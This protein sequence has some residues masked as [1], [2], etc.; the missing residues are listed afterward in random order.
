MTSILYLC[1]DPGIPI[2]GGKGASVHVRA[3][4]HA[5]AELGHHVTVVSPRLEPGGE[6]L[7]AQVSALEIPGVDPKRAADRHELDALKR[8]QT[9]ALTTLVAP[10]SID[11]I[12]ERYSLHGVAGARLAAALGCPLLLE[13]NAPLRD[14]ARRFRSL[15]Y[16]D[17]AL[18]DEREVL[19]AARRVFVVSEPLAEWLRGEGVDAGRI[20]VAPNAFPPPR[21]GP[22]PPLGPDEPA[23]VG[24]AGGLKPWHGI[25]TLVRGFEMALREGARMRLEVAGTG[26][27]TDVLE[28]LS[29][30]AE[31][32]LWHGHLEHGAM[33]GLLGEW[34]IGAAPFTA[35]PGFYFSPLKLGEYMA[36]GL[37]PLVS[38]LP[39]LRAMLEQGRCGML[40][41]PDDPGALCA[42]LLELDRDRELMHRLGS[43]A[44]ERARRGPTWPDIVRQVLAAA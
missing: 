5:M 12:W 30:P 36:A 23:I 2:H 3:L 27:R 7:P 13:V 24:F 22:K 6:A 42:A 41:A 17:G 19:A 39:P 35:V 15:P 11:V 18:A 20:Q 26:P 14:E 28:R 32:F 31:R 4:V 38:D 16:P 33:T 44:L 21:A 9:E 1:A 29:L 40:V 37:C 34:D 10:G 43:R 25:E 8:A